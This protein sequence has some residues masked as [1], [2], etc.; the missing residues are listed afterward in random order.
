MARLRSA[1]FFF[2]RGEMKQQP[3]FEDFLRQKAERNERRTK[4]SADARACEGVALTRRFRGTSASDRFGYFSPDPHSNQWLGD[5]REDTEALANL[6]FLYVARQAIRAN[7][8]AMV[9]AAVQV[10]AEAAVKDPVAQAVAAVASGVYQFLDGHE[11]HWSEMLEARLASL[12]QTS[13]GAFLRSRHN[14]AKKGE[15]VTEKVYSEEE[16]PVEGEY[17]C[18]NCSAGGPLF[19][20]V[21]RDEASGLAT[22]ACPEC[23]QTAE[24]VSEPGAGAVPVPTG[25]RKYNAGDSETEVYTSYQCRV[26]ERRTQGGNLRAARWFEY[27]ELVDRDELEAENPGCDVGSP[28]EWSFPMKWQHALESCTVE[29][30]QGVSKYEDLDIFERRNICL[31]P[32]DYQTYRVP[33]GGGFVLRDAEGQVF[34]EIRDGERPIDKFPEG[35]RFR[36]TGDTILPGTPEDPG[37]APYDFN[38]EWTY[39]GWQTDGLSF[40]MPPPSELVSLNDDFSTLYTLDFQHRERASQTTVAF[41]RMAFDADDFEQELAPTKEGYALPP[42]D[43]LDRHFSVIPVPQMRTAMEGLQLLFDM[44]PMVGQPPPV[45]S[46][47]PDPTDE[48]YGGQRLKRQAALGLLA[49]SQQSKAKAKVAWFKQQL[50]IAQTTWP[51]E[52]F[53]Y[54]RSRFGEEWKEQDIQAFLDADL[55]RVLKLGYAEGSEVPTTLVEREQRMGAFLMQLIQA[56]PVLADPSNPYAADVRRLLAKYADMAGVDYDLGDSEGDERLAKARYDEIRRGLA[57]LGGQGFP[58]E[59]LTVLVL[60]HPRLAVTPKEDHEAHVE[61]W[62]D[63]QRALLADEEPDYMLAALCQEMIN[64]HDAALAAPM[65]EAAAQEQ[66][67]VEGERAAQAEADEAAHAREQEAK[68]AERAHQAGIEAMKLSSQ[69]RQSAVQSGA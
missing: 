53:E 37:V 29:Y 59:E 61:F 17:A 48:T 40:W 42:N 26:D 54:L 55:D 2:S 44:A 7:T 64:L 8:S 9:T 21:A 50:K 49:P 39:T 25:E 14:P 1:G 27:R 4:A 41:D 11:D 16:M 69:E 63:R 34:F 33:A 22:T 57:E 30:L 68:G 52:R 62:S 5:H 66:E 46:G 60:S 13:H 32:E 36:M 10:T 3:T 43:S 18:G 6:K 56:L 65:V 38:D 51:A 35:F 47:A 31:R 23:G 20:E 58:P 15:T 45:A 24:V 12:V 28:A 19:G 67:A